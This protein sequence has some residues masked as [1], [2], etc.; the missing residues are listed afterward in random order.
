[1]DTVGDG[2]DDTGRRR[3]HARR[4]AQADRRDR[5]AA[6]R[7]GGGAEAAARPE[8]GRSGNEK[9][10][11]AGRGPE[12]GGGVVCPPMLAAA[13]APVKAIGQSKGRGVNRY[14]GQNS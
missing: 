10:R 5:T 14:E 1:M 7:D 3:A 9:G 2:G 12:G 6:V 4:L 11:G 13:S 8:G